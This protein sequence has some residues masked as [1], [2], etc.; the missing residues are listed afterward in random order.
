[1]DVRLLSLSE[2]S[3]RQKPRAILPGF[4]YEGLVMLASP[5]GVGKSFLAIHL[6]CKVASAAYYNSSAYREESMNPPKMIEWEGKP[7]TNHGA[8]IY[9]AAEGL[10][11]ISNRIWTALFDQLGSVQKG[12]EI[13]E[14]THMWCHED[15]WKIPLTV[16][17]IPINMADQRDVQKLIDEIDLFTLKNEYDPKLII[18]DTLSRFM[19]GMDENKQ[20][21]MSS[22]VNGCDRLIKNYN[23]AVLVLHHFNK[24]EVAGPRGSSVITGACDQI[25]WTDGEKGNLKGQIV[26]WTTGG[27][28]GKW[29]EGGEITRYFEYV[30]RYARD[31][32]GQMLFEYPS[33]ETEL[34]W[35]PEL[36][37]YTGIR[38]VEVPGWSESTLVMRPIPKEEALWRIREAKKTKKEPSPER[39]GSA[40][41]KIVEA[42]SGN[43]SLGTSALAKVAGMDKGNVSRYLNRM[44]ENGLVGQNVETKEWYL[45]TGNGSANPSLQL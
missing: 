3:D 31:K 38:H 17:D 44:R 41:Q 29:K 14:S 22:F 27:K 2:L 24:S 11:G 35:D 7:I 36:T 33:W 32:R 40:T 25:F 15:P 10:S 34:V 1:M 20:Q 12:E 39:L 23:C 8:V 16:M 37:E 26:K 6:A 42:I 21:D 13:L 30:G 4:L 43:G 19:P 28:Q 18:I 45:V 5:E 9:C